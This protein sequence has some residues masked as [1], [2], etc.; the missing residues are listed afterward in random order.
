MSVLPQYGSFVADCPFS[1]ILPYLS[2]Y[3]R[4]IN[5]TIYAWLLKS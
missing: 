2:R 3:P 1:M 5:I 4:H